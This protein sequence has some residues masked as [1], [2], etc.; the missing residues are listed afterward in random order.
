MDREAMRLTVRRC[1]GI[2]DAA[3]APDVDA[4]IAVLLDEGWVAPLTIAKMV[5]DRIGMMFIR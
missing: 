3:D 5:A 2:N 4:H 1:L